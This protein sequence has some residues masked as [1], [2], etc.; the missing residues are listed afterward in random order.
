VK[1]WL[2]AQR[3]P[4]EEAWVCVRTTAEVIALLETGMVTELSLGHDLGM[5]DVLAWLEKRAARR[6]V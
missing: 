2:D 4:A 6:G 3:P 1:V 5:V